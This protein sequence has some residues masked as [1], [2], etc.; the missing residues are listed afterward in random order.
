MYKVYKS[1]LIVK[2]QQQIISDLEQCKQKKFVEDYTWDYAKYNIFTLNPNSFLL[3]KLFLEL[4]NVVRDYIKSD[5]LW[6]QSWLNYDEKNKFT[7]WHNHSWPYHGYISIRPHNTSTI[8]EDYEIKNEVGNIYIGPGNSRHYVKVN[9]EFN[10]P[11]ITLGF[12][13]KDV[14]TIIYKDMV[15]FIPI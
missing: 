12:D 7:D 10:T 14:K 8:F 6:L 1:E 13:I 4:K 2:N 15:S 3:N 9:E 11:R 5:T